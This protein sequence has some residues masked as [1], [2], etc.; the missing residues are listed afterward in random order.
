MDAYIIYNYT[1]PTALE[2]ST[3]ARFSE[4]FIV[5]WN[6]N[7]PPERWLHILLQAARE[8]LDLH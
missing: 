1:V 3:T 6:H 2:V 7:L 4:A 5:T 8:G